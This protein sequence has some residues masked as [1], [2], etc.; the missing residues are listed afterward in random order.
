MTFYRDMQ[1]IANDLLEEFDQGPLYLL[2]ETPG[3]GPGWNP[4]ESPESMRKQ[5]P[6]TVRGVSQK[7]VDGTLVVATDLQCTMPGGRIEPTLDD[8]I[9]VNGKAHQIVMI[10]PKPASGPVAAYVIVIRK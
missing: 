5:F 10:D 6:G 3:D 4:G 8:R 7:Y 9:E 1:G 2:R